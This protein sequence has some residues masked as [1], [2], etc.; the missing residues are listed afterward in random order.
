[1]EDTLWI[2]DIEKAI[3][4]EVPELFYRLTIITKENSHRGAFARKILT[5]SI[6]SI[7]PG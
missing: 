1:M 4:C 6:H 7:I 5:L 2:Q 3:G